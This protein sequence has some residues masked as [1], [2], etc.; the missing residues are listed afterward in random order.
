MFAG[1]TVFDGSGSPPAAADVAIANGR[2]IEVG[3]G[4][5]GEDRVDVSGL[6]ILPG[7]FDCHTHVL[8][9][10][11]DF[12]DLLET[13]FSYRCFQAAANLRTTLSL[14][15]TSIRDAGGADLGVK[16]AVSGGLLAGPRMRIA[17]NMI[18]QTGGHADGWTASG[19]HVDT[20]F[21][22]HAC[23]PPAVADG[24]DDVRRVARALLRA[25]AD[26]LKVAT[27]GG[28]LSAG[29]DPR[30]GHFRDDELA[31]LA[32]EAAAAKV[33]FMAHAHSA[34]GVKAA[35]RAGA[36]SV[37]HGTLLDDEAIDM[38]RTSGTWL[39]PTLLAPHAIREA[40]A[41]GH[42]LPAAALDQLEEMTHEHRESFRR[43]VDAGVRIAMGT[44]S[45]V[46]PHG[47]NL[48]ELTLMAESG[49]SPAQA[50]VA[51]TSSAAR[52]MGVGDE[53][54][55]LEAGKRADLVFVTGDPLELAE[56]GDRVVAVYQDG[57]LVSGSLGGQAA[58][59]APEAIVIG[60]RT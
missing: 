45:G 9:G 33:P 54:G 1:G 35:V 20:V 47:Q 4:L 31:A 44:D 52:L 28:V 22:V 59:A 8:L 43:A 60:A 10:T 16:R 21:P 56:L 25:G 55:T 58:G 32:A 2:V 27:S 15:I 51:A 48:R 11:L 26:V 49:M 14:G 12:W 46:V 53:L 5:D 29:D 34:D 6:G 24:P 19:Q 50:L 39:V 18:S 37:E 57:L 42:R 23:S 36:H 41:S 3:P 7:L 38:L 13:P 30:H 17:V 40:A